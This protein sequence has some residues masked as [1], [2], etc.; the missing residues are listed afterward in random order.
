MSKVPR[1]QVSVT[2]MRRISRTFGAL[3][4]W[5]VAVL[6]H[7]DELVLDDARHQMQM[8][9]ADAVEKKCSSVKTQVIGPVYM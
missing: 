5:L 6:A 7:A 2:R 1:R 3:C 9:R 8:Q 4:E